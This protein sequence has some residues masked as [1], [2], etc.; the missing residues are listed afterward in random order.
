[1]LRSSWSRW[2]LWGLFGVLLC[3]SVTPVLA[4]G[5]GLEGVGDA[6]TDFFDTL[7]TIL[8]GLALSAAAVSLLTLSL[9]YLLST[10]PP[11]AQYKAQN[12][13][14]MQNVIIGL[15]LI[16][17]VSGGILAGLIAF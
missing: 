11:V 17:L 6:A 12:P 3:L 7:Q 4:Q 14:M 1:M 13:D 15:F 2:M 8:Q 9:I 16:L 5:G 10:W